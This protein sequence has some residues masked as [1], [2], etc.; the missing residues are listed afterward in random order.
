VRLRRVVLAGLAVLSAFAAAGVGQ[1]A[2]P[3]SPPVFRTSG[4]VL[5]IAADGRRVAIAT[6]AIKGCDRAVVW[7][8]PTRA[9]QG[10]ASKVACSGAL[11]H[12][13]PE[14]AIAGNRVEWL[15]TAGGNH[16][17]MV[18]E[19]A[20]LGRP[21]VKMVAFGENQAGAEGGVDGSWIG[22]LAGDGSL[23]VVNTWQECSV[24]RPEGASPCEAGTKVGD[25][26]RS[27]Q[28]LWKLLGLTKA[29]IRSGPDATAVVA[30][31]G[32]RV[33]IQSARDG[34]VI[35]VD[36]RGQK[37]TSSPI[38]AGGDSGTAMQGTRLV[39]LRGL[40]LEAFDTATGK[41]TASVSLPPGKPAPVLRDVQNGLAVYVRGRR[42]HVVRLSDGADVV[43][44]APGTGTVEAQ[45]EAPG[46]Y[47]G[48]GIRSGAEHGR[49]AFVPMA[50]LLTKLG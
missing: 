46:L 30:V 43:F 48:Y 49:V 7:T 27:R 35:I 38:T 26:V 41:P 36:S 20:T 14:I 12:G 47:Y 31:D 19:A 8:A 50:D 23:L 37:L 34:S 13:M 24:F 6:D 32:G 5:A 39:T 40:T 29:R 15:A 44:V 25:V 28:T 42:V 17:D 16:Q 21:Q 33:A 1:A 45:I 9:S 10:F 3:V 18:L 22:D 2:E 4:N 11:F